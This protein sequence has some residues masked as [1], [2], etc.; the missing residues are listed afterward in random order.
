VQL[1][2]RERI[3]ARAARAGVVGLGYVVLLL[4]LEF[5]KVGFPVTV[6][7]VQDENVAR[8]NWGD[9][10]IQDTPLNIFDRDDREQSI[11]RYRDFSTSR[12]KLP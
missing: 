11:C 8:L 4:A 2:L 1:T 3:L 6:I 10:Y 7:D 5:A 9:S 12:K